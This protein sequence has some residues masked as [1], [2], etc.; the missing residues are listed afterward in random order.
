MEAPNLNIGPTFPITPNE[1]EKP[2]PLSKKGVS[3]LL[4]YS[5]APLAVELNL[6]VSY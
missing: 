5:A 6:A 2:L 4:K 1:A 3:F